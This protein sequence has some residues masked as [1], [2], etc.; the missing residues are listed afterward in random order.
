M[1]FLFNL[2]LNLYL[3]LIVYSMPI[4]KSFHFMPQITTF[5]HEYFKIKLIIYSKLSIEFTTAVVMV[6]IYCQPKIVNF[7]NFPILLSDY[8]CFSYY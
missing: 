3:Y 2:S 1:T 5:T 6:L 7:I 4:F 8:S